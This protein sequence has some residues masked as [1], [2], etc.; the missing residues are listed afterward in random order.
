MTNALTL[1]KA[2]DA[3][4]TNPHFKL[5]KLKPRRQRRQEMHDRDRAAKVNAKK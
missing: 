1:V 4:P 3:P 5:Q 2:L